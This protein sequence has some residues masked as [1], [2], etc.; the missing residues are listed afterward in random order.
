MKYISFTSLACILC[1]LVALQA[2]RAMVSTGKVNQ[3]TTE[4]TQ[5]PVG[6]KIVSIGTPTTNESQF[7]FSIPV[8]DIH[9]GSESVSHLNGSTFSNSNVI[10]EKP[11]P[12]I[13]IAKETIAPR[14]PQISTVHINSPATTPLQTPNRYSSG[15]CPYEFKVYV[16]E[17]PSTLASVRLSEE[18]R[19]NKTLH[20]CQKCIL[21]QFSLEYI[22]HDFFTKFCGRTHNPDEAD[23][24]YLP[25][26]RD[27][28]Y[29]LAM[30]D[31]HRKNNRAPSHT[32]QALLDILEK[33]NFSMWTDT[34]QV[35]DKYWR[36]H[37]GADHIIAM[38]APVTNLRHESSKR[39]ELVVVTVTL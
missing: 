20:V 36:A 23:F 34:F 8:V 21:E 24:F 3:V 9:L 25:I 38:P 22:I 32:E 16:Y 29:R 11:S 30:E 33:N 12:I 37:N 18:A 4:S 1:L 17:L 39:G 31:R 2:Y 14:L 10:M 27:A 26:I 13:V 19:K 5:V 28:E 7:S 15:K 35:T 6:M